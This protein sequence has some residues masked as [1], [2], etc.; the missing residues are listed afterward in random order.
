MPTPTLTRFR[1]E[2]EENGKKMK[3]KGEGRTEN[4]N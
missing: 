1:K 4:E 2:S 3:E